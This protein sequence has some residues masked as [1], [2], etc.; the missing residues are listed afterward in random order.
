MPTQF[1]LTPLRLTGGM[2]TARVGYV[3]PV[4]QVVRDEVEVGEELAV[5]DRPDGAMLPHWQGECSALPG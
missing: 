2:Q 5:E 3:P 1:R 4:G